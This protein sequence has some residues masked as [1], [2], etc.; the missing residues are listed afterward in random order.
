MA[1][2]YTSHALRRMQQRG[3][4]AD[5]VERAVNRCIGGPTPGN[6]PGTLVFRGPRLPASSRH[7]KVVVDSAVGDLVISVMFEEEASQ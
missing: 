6:R 2:R 1:L 4:A 7:L 3:I 5:D